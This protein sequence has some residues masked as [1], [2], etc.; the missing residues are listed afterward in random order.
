MVKRRAEKH[1]LEQGLSEVT[2]EVLTELSSRRFGSNMPKRPG[3]EDG[4]SSN[5]PGHPLS[6]FGDSPCNGGLTPI[7]WTAE[8]QQRLEDTPSFLREGVRAVAEDVART[9]GRLE[10]NTKLLDRLE[11]EDEPGRKLNWEDSANDLLDAFLSDRE[12]Q[13]VMFVKPTLEAAAEREAKKRNSIVVATGDIQIILD[14]QLA[15][16]EWDPVALKRVEGAPEFNRAGIKK[17]AEFS[18][19][20]EGLSIITSDDLTRFRN[21]AMMKAVRRLRGFG[22]DELNFDA[23]DIAKKRVPR[24]KDNPQA[25]KRF[26]EI[27]NHVESHQGENGEGLGILDR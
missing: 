22:M 27:R 20:R 4:N 1:V 3:H 18:A 17:A 12:P 9:E 2:S 7:V 25:E 8:A 13:V 10:V 15:G 23:W 6:P 14:T 21:R 19:R 5:T 24:L 16:V 26:G 11:A